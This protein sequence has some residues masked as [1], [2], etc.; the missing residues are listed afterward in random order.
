[1]EN[2][3]RRTI[4]ENNYRIS[5]EEINGPISVDPNSLSLNCESS[6]PIY[7]KKKLLNIF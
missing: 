3:D 2:N 6:L 4:E 7:K 1:V 5:S